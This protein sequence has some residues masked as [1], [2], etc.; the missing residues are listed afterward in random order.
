M[1]STT[2][3]ALHS[4]SIVFLILLIDQISKIW[5]KT[6]FF[7]GE[8]IQITNFFSLLFVENEG[9]AFGMSFGDKIY[10]TLFRIA[11]SIGILAF[12][13][14]QIKKNASTMLIVSISLIFA[15]AFGNIID[16]VFYGQIFDYAPYFYGKVVDMLYFPLIEGNYWNWI[17]IVGGDHFIFFSAIFN[18]ADSAITIGVFLIILFERSIFK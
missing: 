9:M 18:I 15:G 8:E 14:Y 7:Y 17:P 11:A 6:S 2:K 16:C 4:A 10:L 1:Q 3:K 13:I 5:I 12:L